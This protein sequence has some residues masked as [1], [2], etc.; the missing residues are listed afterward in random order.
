[1]RKAAKVLRFLQRQVLPPFQR[2]LPLPGR[3]SSPPEGSSLNTLRWFSPSFQE[4][5]WPSPI[6]ILRTRMSSEGVPPTT[7]NHSEFQDSSPWFWFLLSDSLI[8]ERW[9]LD[10]LGSPRFQILLLLGA[11]RLW[12]NGPS[13]GLHGAPLAGGQVSKSTTVSALHLGVGEECG[14]NRYHRQSFFKD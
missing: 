12:S 11:Q 13:P 4:S 5:G 2:Q 10:V 1:M 3:A 6:V 14:V 7:T 8:K 9:S